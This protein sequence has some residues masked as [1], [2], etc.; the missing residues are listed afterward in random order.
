MKFS[1]SKEA[2]TE[3]LLKARQ[4]LESALLLRLSILGVDPDDFD[5]NNFTPNED[6]TLEK[7]IKNTID[8]IKALDIRLDSL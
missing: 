4:D 5:E 7:D 2:K 1:I 3:I 6:S 8:K